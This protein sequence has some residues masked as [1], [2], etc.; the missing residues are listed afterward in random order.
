MHTCIESSK[1]QNFAK[2]QIILDSPR[3]VELAEWTAAVLLL[4]F[5]WRYQNG[6]V[7]IA[8]QSFLLWTTR[9]DIYI[10]ILLQVKTV[11]QLITF[12]VLFLTHFHL[13]R[14]RP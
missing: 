5:R 10:Y 12:H 7:H 8:S 13:G 4:A 1:G 3:R 9:H 6:A 14:H 11:E 2:T